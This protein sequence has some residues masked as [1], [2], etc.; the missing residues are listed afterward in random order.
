MTATH[1]RRSV[2]GVA[3]IGLGTLAAC[4]GAGGGAN[5]PTGSSSA[6]TIALDVPTTA[7]AYV[8]GAIQRG[9]SL[10]VMEANARGLSIAGTRHKI[11]LRVYD[12]DAQPAT[13]AQNVSSAIN[14]GAVA[15]IEDGLGAAVSA[16]AAPAQACRRSSSPTARPR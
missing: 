6:I 14:D 15:V 3:L 16:P 13:S 8:A 10:A 5:A 4:G 1:A 11:A 12:D 9:A 2:A 7:D